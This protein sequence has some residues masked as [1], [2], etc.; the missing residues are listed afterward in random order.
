MYLKKYFLGSYK[1]GA[2][3]SLVPFGSLILIVSIIRELG[4]S[5]THPGL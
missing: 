2:T 1:A 4:F 3:P 5:P